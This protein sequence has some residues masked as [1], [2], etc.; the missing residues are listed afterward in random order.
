MPAGGGKMRFRAA[1]VPEG[2]GPQCS[3]CGGR[4]LIGGPLY[5]GRYYD[6]DFVDMCLEVLEN[7]K[8][9]LPGLT[10]QDRI[11]GMLT[12]LREELPDVALHY[13]LPSLCT[14]NK[15]SM[16]RPSCFMTKGIDLSPPSVDEKNKQP[17][18]QVPRWLPNPTPNWGP[19]SRAGKRRAE[20][21]KDEAS[22]STKKPKEERPNSN[23]PQGD[24]AGGPTAANPLL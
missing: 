19:K 3:E 2:V 8:E 9:T 16:I 7:S 21:D 24:N 1:A 18:R 22:S 13:Q 23:T 17:G 11:R 12:A 15:L 6:P 5:S 4:C 10:M 14:R 20:M